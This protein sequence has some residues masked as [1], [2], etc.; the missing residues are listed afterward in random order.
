M[1]PLIEREYQTFSFQEERLMKTLD[2]E[3]DNLQQYAQKENASAAYVARQNRLLGSIWSYIEATD[4]LL[5]RII[6]AHKMVAPMV[7]EQQSNH[8]ERKRL[9]E[10]VFKLKGYLRSLGKDP[11][12]IQ[13]MSVR[14]FTHY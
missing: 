9:Q 14:D 11:D 3:R 8:Y 2:R 5:D 1:N 4:A 13:F 6:T 12:L 7:E 10:E